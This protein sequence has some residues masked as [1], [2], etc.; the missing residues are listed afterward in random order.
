MYGM[1]SKPAY[2]ARTKSVSNNENHQTGC[3]KTT[4]TRVRLSTFLICRSSFFPVNQG[5]S[6]FLRKNPIWVIINP[7]RRSAVEI[8]EDKKM[9]EAD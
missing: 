2:K 1:G 3:A 7:V 6:F 9:G 8:K 4:K 5:N